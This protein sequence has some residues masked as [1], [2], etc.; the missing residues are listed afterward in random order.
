[1]KKLW[2]YIVGFFTFVVGILLLSGK[3]NKKVKELKKSIKKVNKSIKEKE[4]NIKEV[5]KKI[6]SKKEDLKKIKSKKYVK[7]N[8]NKKET[9]DFLKNFSKKKK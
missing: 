2:K 9:E 1:M 6:K 3:K 5:D 8:T 7:K 4:K